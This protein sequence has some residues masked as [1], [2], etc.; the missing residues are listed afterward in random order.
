MAKLTPDG[1]PDDRGPRPTSKR[2]VA[3]TIAVTSPVPGPHKM[4][5]VHCHA[6]IAQTVLPRPF[7]LE[8]LASIPGPADPSQES[9]RRPDRVERRRD[10][11]LCQKYETS[12][13]GATRRRCY[14]TRRSRSPKLLGLEGQ[15]GGWRGCRSARRSDGA[16]R[17]DRVVKRCR[18]FSP[19][20]NRDGPSRGRPGVGSGSR[21]LPVRTGCDGRASRRRSRR[22]RT[23]GESRPGDGPC[24][25]PPRTSTR[26]G[27][28]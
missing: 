4:R 15:E 10:N 1:M 23:R 13:G 21:R 26:A 3:S 5:V 7:A 16:R 24:G 17:C 9:S 22:D 12:S 19:S 20:I 6:Q 11:F 18:A 14:R 8:P 2:P 28:C 25:R 27:S